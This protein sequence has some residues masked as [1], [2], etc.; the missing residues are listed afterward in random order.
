M[1]NFNGMGLLEIKKVVY[2]VKEFKYYLY[3]FKVLQEFLAARYLTRLKPADETQLQT[4]VE[5]A[6]SV[7]QHFVLKDYGCLLHA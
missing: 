2:G 3:R 5:C 6:F 7:C 4:Q 1:Q